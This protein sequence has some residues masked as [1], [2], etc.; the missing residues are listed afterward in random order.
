[1]SM[2]LGCVMHNPKGRSWCVMVETVMKDGSVRRFM[3]FHKTHE[4]ARRIKDAHENVYKNDPDVKISMF[5]YDY[6]SS[7]REVITRLIQEGTEY[8]MEMERK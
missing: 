4:V 1:M 8:I 2:K 3:S 5:E 6:I 7:D